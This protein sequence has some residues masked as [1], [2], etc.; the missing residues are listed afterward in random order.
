MSLYS[1][2]IHRA[3]ATAAGF[4]VIIATPSVL[5]FLFF[6]LPDGAAPPLTIG[7]VNLVAFALTISMTLITTPL[8]VRLAHWMDPTPSETRLCV[9]SDSGGAQHAENRDL[10]R[11][12]EFFRRGWLRFPSD[13]RLLGW[14]RHAAPAAL[15]AARSPEHRAQWLRCEG[16]WFAGVDVLGNDAEGRIGGSGPL[17]GQAA[18]FVAE[19]DRATAG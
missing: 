9:F 7:A 14:L 10:E 8:G 17:C 2:A 6:D 18:D 13:D 15:A 3:V 1:M 19:D 12:T 5:G 16:T 11:L 4:G